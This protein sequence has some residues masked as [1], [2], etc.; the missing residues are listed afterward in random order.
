VDKNLLSE[1][2]QGNQR[3]VQ[4]RNMMGARENQKKYE[5]DISQGISPSLAWLAREG[6]NVISSIKNTNSTV[7]A[8]SAFE[9]AGH[10]LF[11]ALTIALLRKIFK[12]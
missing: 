10:L 5:Q 8:Q 12:K 1:F 9:G 7:L 2:A 6:K 3:M 4:L 11:I